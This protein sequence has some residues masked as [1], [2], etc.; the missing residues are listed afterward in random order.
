MVNYIKRQKIKISE[1]ASGEDIIVNKIDIL[2]SKD[3]APSVY[4]QASMHAAELQGNAIIHELLNYFEKHQPLGNIT[5][6]PQCNPIGRDMLMGTSH[7]GRFDATNGDNWNRYYFNPEIDYDSFANKHINSDEKTYKKA[8]RELLHKEID[9]LTQESQN[10]SRAKNLNYSMQKHALDADIILD[11]HTEDGLGI[12][13][14]Y[15]PEYSNEAAAYLGFDD[16]LVTQNILGGALHNGALQYAGYVP[17]WSLQKSFA[18]LGKETKVLVDTYTLELGSQGC[19]NE[20]RA[21]RKSKQILNYLIFKNVI[22]GKA[23]KHEANYHGVDS[24]KQLYAPYGGLY[25]WQVSL[26][27]IVEKGDRLGYCLQTSVN[28]KHEIIA[29]FK[30]KI[31]G[32]HSQ[33]AVQKHCHTFN[34]IKL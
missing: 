4:I 1:N 24:Y 3:T 11:L 25:E 19:I 18:K 8:F 16:V 34:V 15:S 23:T 31:L 12:E 5:I 21:I 29:P 14:L 27:D 13:Y 33:G 2:G 28:K 17:W 22:D 10:L 32:I 20:Q 30:F 26:G 9:K 6:I 7:L